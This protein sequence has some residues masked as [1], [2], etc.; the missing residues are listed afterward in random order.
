MFIQ[1]IDKVFML[2]ARLTEKKVKTQ[3][4]HIKERKEL[5][6]LTLRTAKD[7]STGIVL[8]QHAQGFGKLEETDES[9]EKH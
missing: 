4:I 3:I 9:L 8:H 6:L 7:T 2:I 1:N 5:P